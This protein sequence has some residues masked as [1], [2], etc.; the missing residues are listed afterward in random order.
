M[1]YPH[2]E[3]DEQAIAERLAQYDEAFGGVDPAENK[4]FEPLP[5]GNY[6]AKVDRAV[7]AP[8]KRSDRD[9]LTITW[10]IIGP[11]HAGRLVWDR[12]LLDRPDG[13]PFLKAMLLKMGINLSQL[14]ELP[15][16]CHLMLDRYA[17]IYIKQAGEFTN[18]Y[19]NKQLEVA[20]T[21][22]PPVEDAPPF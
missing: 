18:V 5:D 20:T 16:A 11:T 4:E 17:E 15:A 2:N 7:V 13:W 1:T 12:T 22:A 21:D 3:A 8:S 9:M 10:S 6:Q 19:V 14:S